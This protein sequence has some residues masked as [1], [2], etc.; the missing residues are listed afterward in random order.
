MFVLQNLTLTTKARRYALGRRLYTFERQN[1]LYWLKLQCSR[2]ESST[3]R[4]FYNELSFYQWAEQYLTHI[5]PVQIIDKA[6]IEHSEPIEPYAIVLPHAEPVFHLPASELSLKEIYTTIDK[7]LG[8]LAEF[9][10]INCIHGDLK[11]E[12]FVKFNGSVCLID[13]E[14]AIYPS[15][16]IALQEMTATPRLMAPE[17]FHGSYKTIQSDLYAF[18][19]ILYEWLSETRLYAKGYRDWAY[20]HC[21]KFYPVLPERYQHLLPLFK[22]L[23]EK[24]KEQRC[25]TVKQAKISF[26]QLKL[27][28]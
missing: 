7:M 6:Q 11:A 13:F 26:E 20:L 21:Q 17:L 4:S 16:H 8:A 24:Q 18:G 22:I 27:S 10:G 19:I 1:Q 25:A 28:I 15:C 12:H 2:G 5:L 23:L 9:E 14:Q 3:Q